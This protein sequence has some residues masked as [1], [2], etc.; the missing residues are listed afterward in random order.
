MR[1]NRSRTQ[2]MPSTSAYHLPVRGLI[3]FTLTT[4]TSNIMKWWYKFSIPGYTGLSENDR[5]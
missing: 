5:H 2:I 1:W 4:F 3:Y